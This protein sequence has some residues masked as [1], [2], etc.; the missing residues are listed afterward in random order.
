MYKC[1][2]SNSKH[3]F[4]SILLSPNFPLSFFFPQVKSF[5]HNSARNAAATAIVGADTAALAALGFDD[6][7]GGGGD[8]G[9]G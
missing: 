6:G 5:L 4:Q 1:A 2:L 7:A 8:G 9:G 3:P